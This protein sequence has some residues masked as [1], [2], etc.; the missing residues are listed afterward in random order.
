LAW[1]E[2]IGFTMDVRDAKRIDM[3]TYVA[4]HELGHQWWA[5]QVIGANV[6][7]VTMLDETF[8]QYSAIMAM[9]K[10]Y[11][12]DQIRRFLKYEQDNYLK[13]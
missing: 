1:S 9:E 12:R 6:Q 4:A 11:G 3:V 2:G 10:L 5:H 13:A 7:G 8:A